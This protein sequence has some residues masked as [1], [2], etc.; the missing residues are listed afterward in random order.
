MA[1]PTRPVSYTHLDVYK[2]QTLLCMKQLKL[3]P[4][5]QLTLRVCLFGHVRV[6]ATIALPNLITCAQKLKHVYICI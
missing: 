5:V 3:N 4:G 1:Y 6:Y 2:R